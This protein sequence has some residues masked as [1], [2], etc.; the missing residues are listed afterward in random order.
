MTVNVVRLILARRALDLSL[1]VMKKRAR[2]PETKQDRERQRHFRDLTVRPVG[3]CLNQRR[4]RV[5][6][7]YRITSV[8]LLAQLPPVPTPD[9][10]LDRPPQR[11]EALG[12][13]TRLV[14]QPRQ[15]VAQLRVV[16]FN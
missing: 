1:D 4:D 15:E 9:E 12:K 7:V 11:L 6:Q 16:T 13:A 14:R 2:I 5:N 3:D 10:Q 8:P